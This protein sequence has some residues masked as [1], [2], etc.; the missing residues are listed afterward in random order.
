MQTLFNQWLESPNLG[1]AEIQIAY[2]QEV[3]RQ[4]TQRAEAL[5]L[6]AAQ[7]AAE[8]ATLVAQKETAQ[9]SEVLAVLHSS[10]TERSAGVIPTGITLTQA[11]ELLRTNFAQSQGVRMDDTAPTA[12]GRILRIR[13]MTTAELITRS[14]ATSFGR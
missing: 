5:Q 1:F 12:Q 2:Q 4:E 7:A 11:T 9:L 6:E 8:H 14:K 3:A 10:N 13:N